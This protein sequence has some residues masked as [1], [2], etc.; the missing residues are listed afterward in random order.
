MKRRILSSVLALV[1][2]LGL[3]IVPSISVNAADAITVD[4][5][6]GEWGLWTTVSAVGNKSAN[7]TVQNTTGLDL[8]ASYDYAVKVV[9]DTLYVAVKQDAPAVA[10]PEGEAV[11]QTNCTNIRLW[12]DN[13]MSTTARSALFDFGF[14]GE[15]VVESR[16]NNDGTNKIASTAACVATETGYAVEIAIKTADLGLG[17]KFGYALT[18]SAPNYAKGGL[19]GS[20]AD[21]S[22]NIK[23]PT[24]VLEPNTEY[25]ITATASFANVD[26]ASGSAFVNF[27]Y[28]ETWG[29]IFAATADAAE[30]TAPGMKFTTGAEIP[31]DIRFD[32]TIGTWGGAKGDIQV[33]SIQILKGTDVVYEEK[34]GVVP[35]TVENYLEGYAALHSIIYSAGKEPWT[36]TE[37]YNVNSDVTVNVL[38]GSSASYTPSKLYLLSDGAAAEDATAF[39]DARYMSIQNTGFV[40]GQ[41]DPVDATV[42]FVRDL[43]EIKHVTGAKLSL[44]VDEASMIGA[45]TLVK[46]YGSADGDC[47]YELNAGG[48]IAIAEDDKKEIALT[49]D[50]SK[51]AVFDLQYVKAVVTIDYG[52]I[53]ASEFDV[54]TVAEP[55]AGSNT[56]PAGPYAFDWNTTDGVIGVYTPDNQ[57]EGGFVLSEPLTKNAQLIKLKATDVAGKYD[58]TFNLCNP[59]PD[60]HSGTMTLAEDELLVVLNTGGNLGTGKTLDIKSSAKWAARGLTTDNTDDG[61]GCGDFVVLDFYDIY[62]FPAT[63]K[64]IPAK[65]AKLLYVN[66]INDVI[67]YSVAGKYNE[68]NTIAGTEGY[69]AIISDPAKLA[70]S[71]AWVNIAYFAPTAVDGIY[72]VVDT[73]L[74]AGEATAPLAFPEGGFVYITNTGNDWPALCKAYKEA[75][76]ADPNTTMEKPWY[77]DQYKDTPNFQTPEVNGSFSAIPTLVK[78]MKA[79]LVNINL[80]LSVISDRFQSMI[81]VDGAVKNPVANP[82]V[83]GALTYGE[84]DLEGKELVK[85]DTDSYTYVDA[86]DAGWPDDSG[87]SLLDGVLNTDNNPPKGEN[88]GWKGK[89][90][91]SIDFKFAEAT[92]VYAVEIQVRQLMG[93]GISRGTEVQYYGTTDGENY[94]YIGTGYISAD[95]FGEDGTVADGIYPYTLELPVYAEGLTGVRVALGKDGTGW[96]FADEFAAYT[97]QEPA[98]ETSEP[99][100]SIPEE[101]TPDE[102]SSVPVPPTGETTSIVLLALAL[103]L[104]CGAVVVAKKRRA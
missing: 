62:F 47:W 41:E 42:E 96:L 5:N 59:W 98:P 69:A 52:W 21:T 80:E 11:A 75:L 68:K 79:Q 46:F 40:H 12:I 44:F 14:D 25:T 8:N 91:Y 15:K 103:V 61:L 4:G 84:I 49:L 66:A 95:A 87:N 85:I 101:S 89:T 99:E 63:H 53:F 33:K 77:Y 24:S 71:Y 88:P 92:D 32:S 43:G 54:V 58:I 20:F 1:M 73:Q 2:L 17:E 45:P 55:E 26:K 93:W 48:K 102:E 3:M 30:A 78:G 104:V 97:A 38:E 9:G 34:F 72:T 50:F 90:S 36:T 16:A 67:N 81:V 18:V 7:G 51:R 65:D 86:P 23:L 6:V 56:N 27:Y 39:S 60:G 82:Y 10:A 70:T 100:E 57:P 29:D 94:F 37:L 83:D 76:E 74:I 64:D 13:D 19:K 31:A 35:E 22:V 28:G